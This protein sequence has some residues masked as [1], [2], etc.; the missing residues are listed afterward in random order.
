MKERRDMTTTRQRAKDDGKDIMLSLV[1]DVVLGA[2][3]SSVCT[4]L[5][6]TMDGALCVVPLA[7]RLICRSCICGVIVE[8]AGML[9][10]KCVVFWYDVWR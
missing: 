10:V 6:L 4:S 7:R 3:V 1:D 8:G 2:G 9:F 5:H